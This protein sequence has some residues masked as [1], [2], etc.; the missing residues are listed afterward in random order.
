MNE[1][2]PAE[3]EP[4]IITSNDPMVPTGPEQVEQTLA[5]ALGAAEAG[6][7]ILHH[8]AIPL[9]RGKDERLVLDVDRS[10]ELF[11]GIRAGSNAILQLGITLATN[12]SRMAVARAAKPDMMSITISDNDHYPGDTIHR[13]REEM[14]ELAQFCLDND[15]VPEWEIFHTGGL[16]NLLYLIKM[17]VAKP[18]FWINL[19]LYQEGSCWSPR[20]PAEIDH[21]ASLLPAEARWHLVAFAR[22][23]ADPVV[24]PITPV[25]HTRLLTHAMLRGGGIRTGKEDRPDLSPGVPAT[26]NAELITMAAEISHQIGRPV[27]TPDEARRLLGVRANVPAGG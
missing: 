24:E 20:T 5:E 14:V 3:L 23:G 6:A 18:P 7:T 4:L 12:E 13:D 10:A 8:H 21:R 16:W 25:E 1:I 17:G 19:C 9:P 2:R 26:S 11:T 22:A 15:I 27:A